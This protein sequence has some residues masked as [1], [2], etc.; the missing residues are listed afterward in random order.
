MVNE[1]IFKDKY[2]D[3]MR[4][5]SMLVSCDICNKLPQIWWLKKQQTSVL[6]QFWSL[7]SKSRYYRVG[8]FF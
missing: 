5:E 7:K 4:L 1:G 3:L 8:F 6:S 2:W